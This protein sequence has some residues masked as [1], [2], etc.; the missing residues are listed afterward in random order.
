MGLD[1]GRWSRSC[2]DGEAAHF[3]RRGFLRRV[4][5]HRYEMR[6]SNQ[7]GQHGEGDMDA[8]QRLIG[9]GMGFGAAREQLN[10]GGRVARLKVVA[11][12]DD[13]KQDG[14]EQYQSR[15]L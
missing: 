5:S 8:G 13:R 12:G 10:F 15:Q 14:G 2:G 11:E 3:R 4:G 9:R 6:N 1:G 7:A